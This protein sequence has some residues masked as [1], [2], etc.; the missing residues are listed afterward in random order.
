MG[1]SR[2]EGC[3]YSLRLKMWWFKG[4]GRLEWLWVV[5]EDGG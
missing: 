5:G 2:I 1:A 3:G 4:I